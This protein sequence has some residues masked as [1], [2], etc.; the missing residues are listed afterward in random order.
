MRALVAETR[1]HSGMGRQ[2]RR[3]IDGIGGIDGRAIVCGRRAIYVPPMALYACNIRTTVTGRTGE[4]GNRDAINSRLL[5]VRGIPLSEKVTIELP[6]EL[7]RRARK[8][9]AVGNRHL[10]DAVID[11][12]NRAVSEPD[13]EVLPDERPG[14]F[15]D[16]QVCGCLDTPHWS[17]IG[18]SAGFGFPRA[19]STTAVGASETRHDR[20]NNGRAI[21]ERTW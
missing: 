9:A 14:G 15:P 5:Q 20:W 13:V 19:S 10:E 3:H 12:I 16:R 6:D 11:R 17:G 2:H 21:S 7:S 18:N 1:I 8:L 4:D